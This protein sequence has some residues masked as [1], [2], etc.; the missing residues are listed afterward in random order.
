MI[1][2][3]Q[4]FKILSSIFVV[5]L[6]VAGYWY[7][8]KLVTKTSGI[9]KRAFSYMGLAFILIFVEVNLNL[10]IYLPEYAG[11]GQYFWLYTVLS[12]VMLPATILILRK[13]ILLFAKIAK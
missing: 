2:L 3:L 11:F 9:I 4:T 7:M 6:A 10:A 1:E 13:A 5:A 12:I 8:K